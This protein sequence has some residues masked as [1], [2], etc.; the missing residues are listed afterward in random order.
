[1]QAL[2]HADASPASRWMPTLLATLLVMLCFTVVLLSFSRPDYRRFAQVAEGLGAGFGRAGALGAEPVPLGNAVVARSFAPAGEPVPV[3]S[4]WRGSGQ[5]P[6]LVMPAVAAPAV[7]EAPPPALVDPVKSGVNA[8][9]A[10]TRAEA[11]RLAG[12]FGPGIARGEIE[13]EARGRSAVLRVLE[14]GSFAA[15]S[16]TLTPAMQSQ[17]AELGALLAAEPGEFL[18]RSYHAGA[19][20][21]A[22]S[23]W[24]LSAARAAAVAE[25]LQAPAPAIAERLTVLAYGATRPPA[26]ARVRTGRV[27]RVDIVI[28]RTL[29][30][31]LR[32]ALDALRNHTPQSAATFEALL[33]PQATEV[34]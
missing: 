24:F 20:P 23:D 32:V 13:I 4:P 25:A 33:D 1:M 7:P 30:P 14:K 2:T 12:R 9:I 3:D 10:G 6:P 29:T 27:N 11:G 21:G 17:L 18:L 19:T 34:P 26:D 31:E 8:L 5:L 28:T 16:P 15:G 22:P